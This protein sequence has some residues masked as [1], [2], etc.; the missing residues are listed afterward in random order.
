MS[1]MTD[2][3]TWRPKSDASTVP[4]IATAISEFG[5]LIDNLVHG[6]EYVIGEL[7][8]SNGSP[9]HRCVPNGKSSN[10]IFREGCIEY[11]VRTEF[12]SQT[13]RTSKDTAKANVLS[14][15]NSTVIGLKSDRHGIIN[16]RE[17][18]H[19]L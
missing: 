17:E 4:L 16:G 3:A 18:I 9:T 2:S 19:F 15:Y 10:T 14:K 13:L 1:T 8:L 7:Y 12:V 5:H 11:S 6:W